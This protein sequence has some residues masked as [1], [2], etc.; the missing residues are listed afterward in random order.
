[1]KRA[2][3]RKSEFVCDNEQKREERYN[4]KEIE[5]VNERGNRQL[6]RKYTQKMIA[7]KSEK[8]LGLFSPVRIDFI[9]NT[10]P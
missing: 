7:L 9:S 3:D 2:R 8:V 6:E 10:K 1:M 4:E 5:R